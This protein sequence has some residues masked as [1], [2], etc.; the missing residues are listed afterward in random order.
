MRVASMLPTLQYGIQQSDDQLTTALTQL[1]T[2]K[3]VNALSDDPAASEAMVRSL[4]SSA[5]NDRYTSNADAVSSRMQAADAA[6]SAVVT[7]LNQAV[8]IGTSGTD[9]TLTSSQRQGLADQMRDLLQTVVS[10]A[11][12]TFQ[13]AYLFAGSNTTVKPFADDGSGGYLYNGNGAVL[14]V[15]VGQSLSVDTNV[16]GDQ[17]FT[18]GANVIGSLQ[19]LVTALQGGTSDD[20]SSATIAVSSA[21]TYVGEQRVPL[22]NTINQL[23][24]QESYLSQE[25]VTLT[26]QQT[27][28]VRIDIA[29]AATN[30]S[31]AELTQSAVQAAVAKSFS[32]TLFDYLQ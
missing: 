11:N 6:L 14:R 15:Q 3:R 5:A 28:L 20:I 29:V 17:V 16:P 8:T 13:G 31:Q 7:S 12:T 32:H 19:K 10:Q 30:L 27:N 26:T 25:S 22:E 21:L 9:T 4:A 23:S 24:A 1:T 18:A 2:Q